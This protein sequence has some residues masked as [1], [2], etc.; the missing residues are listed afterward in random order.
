MIKHITREGLQK[1]IENKED[2]TLINVLSVES[3]EKEHIPGSINIPW[4]EI[5]IADAEGRI[6]KDKTV[7][8][9]CG[10][11]TCDASVKAAIFLE[12]LKYKVIEYDG[13]MIDWKS[14]LNNAVHA[15]GKNG[16]K[17]DCD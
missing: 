7:I 5:P 16:I 6:P 12:V 10:S 4:R 13:G 15:L 9:Y 3:F 11:F 1:L 8:V 17:C 2:F 14:D